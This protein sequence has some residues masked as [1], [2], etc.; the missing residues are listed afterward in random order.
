MAVLL[1][2]FVAA[3]AFVSPVLALM[4]LSVRLAHRGLGP[5]HR[6]I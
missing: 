6:R 4:Y 5:P 2:I 1:G 3:L